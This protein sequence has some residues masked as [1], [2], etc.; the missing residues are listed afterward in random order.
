MKLV[1]VRQAHRF[2]E[3]ALGAY[4]AKHLDGFSERLRISQFDAGQSNPT[5]LLESES[6][7]YVL[8]KKPPGELLPKAHMV[9]REY[10]VMAS[11][12]STAV[13][14]PRV[15]HLCEDSTIIGTPFFVMEFLEGRVFSDATLPEAKSADRALLHEAMVA[16]LA[17][18]HEVDYDALALGDFGKPGN[19]F[20]RQVS[21]WTRQYKAAQTDNIPSIDRLI[22]WLPNDAPVN[23]STSLVH[24]DYRMDNV[25]FHPFEPRII[26]V[27]DWELSTL[28]HPSCRPCLLLPDVS[29]RHPTTRRLAS[30]AGSASGIPTEAETIASYCR[31]TGRTEIADW[32]YY[33]AFSMFRL[34]GIAQ[35]VYKRGLDG[36]ASSPRALK[37]GKK[38][39]VLSNTAWAL[40]ES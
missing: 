33:M 14:V 31:H 25:I 30:L 1:A 37:M 5:F 7:S 8:R 39:A 6:A 2:D 32:P 23:D 24:G 15:L 10:R 35:G 18:L 34:A 9:E 16:T 29:R 4:L 40:V 27:L 12:A 19:Y 38:V 20:E 17:A 36:N 3:A 21:R 22:A 28:G 13:P 11:L 26:G